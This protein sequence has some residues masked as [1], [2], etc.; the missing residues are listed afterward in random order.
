M[1]IKI[2][3]KKETKKNKKIKIKTKILSYL[4]CPHQQKKFFQVHSQQQ[5]VANHPNVD[6][7]S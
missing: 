5:P 4:L 6:F 1:K 7:R 2:Q 3:N